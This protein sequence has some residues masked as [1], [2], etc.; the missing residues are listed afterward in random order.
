MGEKA[1]IKMP[2]GVKKTKGGF[3]TLEE[4]KKNY[5]EDWGPC[6]C[7]GSEFEFSRKSGSGNIKVKCKNCGRESEVYGIK[8]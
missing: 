2:S 6:D 4:V 8:D 5:L 1:K 7:G 3:M